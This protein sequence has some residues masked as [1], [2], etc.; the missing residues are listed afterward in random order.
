MMGIFDKLMGAKDIELT[1][2]SALA[3]AAMTIIGADGVIEDV[4]LASLSRIVR[5]DQDS[6]DR[7]FKLYK[8]L[9]FEKCVSLVSNTLDQKQKIALI[10]IL[11]DIA[12]A[13][14]ILAGAEKNLLELYINSFQISEDIIKSIV[15]VI[16]LKIM[17]KMIL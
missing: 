14:G 7:A 5:G 17:L 4:E 11:L 6:F 1:P 3:L 15:E 16:A 2:K 12:M 13:D 9:S 10:A 8:D